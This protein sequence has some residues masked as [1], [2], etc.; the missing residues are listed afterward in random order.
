VV[1]KTT[2]G[3]LAPTACL[4]E[5]NLKAKS[6]VILAILPLQVLPIGLITA[7]M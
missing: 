3:E 1:C 2:T 5:T 6:T 4:P 7:S